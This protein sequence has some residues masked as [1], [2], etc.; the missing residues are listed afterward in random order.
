MARVHILNPLHVANG[1]HPPG[2]TLRDYFA[3]SQSAACRGWVSE[4]GDM[5]TRT[6]LGRLNPLHVAD[7][8]QSHALS[9]W[10]V[11][12]SQSAACRGWVSNPVADMKAGK[13]LS[14]SAACRGWVSNF[15][16]ST[17][18]EGVKSLNPLH[19]ADG[20]QTPGGRV[21]HGT[22]VSIRCMS[23]MGVK[24]MRAWTTPAI[25]SQSAACRGWVSNMGEKLVALFQEVSIRCMSRMG[26]KRY[27]SRRSSRP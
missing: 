13:A 9:L 10:I 21:R 18:G 17:V 25:S 26:V 27:E 5:A 6:K 2:M 4:T 7:G 15:S 11:A 23:R 1:C 14:Q 22:T 20:C 3:G 19:V 8:C 16:F 12:E 24:R